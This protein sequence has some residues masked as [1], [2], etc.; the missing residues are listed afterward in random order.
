MRG[1]VVQL[2]CPV[3]GPSKYLA[4]FIH[5]ACSD[6]NLA[7]LFREFRLFEGDLHEFYFI[8]THR[9]DCILGFVEMETPG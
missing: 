5:K 3:S 9:L 2:Y 7:S 6:G 4:P 8:G 1:G